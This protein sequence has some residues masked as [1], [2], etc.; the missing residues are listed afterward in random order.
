[1]GVCVM[2]Y[3]QDQLTVL[4]LI[5]TQM[6]LGDFSPAP[7]P[8]AAAG[9]GGGGG[10]GD[11]G[12]ATTA[13][14]SVTAGSNISS[15]HA[16]LLVLP[17]LQLLAFSTTPT[18]KAWALQLYQRL[19]PL[20]WPQQ[21]LTVPVPQSTAVADVAAAEGCSSG[22]GLTAVDLN[23]QG[24]MAGVKGVVL[25]LDH[26]VGGNGRT[27]VASHHPQ[28]L[29][30]HRVSP[31]VTWCSSVKLQLLQLQQEVS[32]SKAGGGGATAPFSVPLVPARQLRQQQ[33]AAGAGGGGGGG[34]VGLLFGLTEEVVGGS[35][36]ALGEVCLVLAALMS[37]ED[38]QVGVWALGSG[39]GR[40]GGGGGGHGGGAFAC[41]IEEGW[42]QE[43]S[44]QGERLEKG[45][46]NCVYLAC[47]LIFGQPMFFCEAQETR[48][49]E[50]EFT[51]MII[52]L[53]F[54]A[55]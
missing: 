43:E 40:G 32:S 25:L 20:L 26:L 30:Q 3:V 36:T 23:C 42:V 27:A 46:Y 10:G 18:A 19:T 5:A 13:S 49:G 35:V 44:L 37:N 39:R 29:Q 28:Q 51:I 9:G 52:S 47:F 53:H 34:G 54:A 1:M 31:A 50:M 55:A 7:A 15:S 24:E 45:L 4:Q 33:G 17:L 16:A 2:L 22:G 38:P 14:S 8:A 21:S 6:P 41:W 48:S 11:G 12:Q